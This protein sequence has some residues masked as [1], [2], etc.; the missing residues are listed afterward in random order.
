MIYT[1]YGLDSNIWRVE[2]KPV[3]G[4][5]PES[6]GIPLV[7]STRQDVMP[8]LSPDGHKLAFASDRSYMAIGEFSGDNRPPATL[9]LH[10][11]NFARYPMSNGLSRLATRFLGEP[12]SLDAAQAATGKALDA[13]DLGREDGSRGDANAGDT[14]EVVGLA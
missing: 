11:V 3:S 7:A 12:A 13:D 10:A 6:P 5:A 1:K 2:I 8:R 4:G 14:I 9:T